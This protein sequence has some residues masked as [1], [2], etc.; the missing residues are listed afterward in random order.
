MWWLQLGNSDCDWGQ[1][2]DRDGLVT[3]SGDRASGLLPPSV[4][5]LGRVHPGANIQVHI[6]EYYVGIALEEK[7]QCRL[8]SPTDWQSKFVAV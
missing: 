7:E 3:E 8:T 2:T 6:R 5:S 1:R 4:R